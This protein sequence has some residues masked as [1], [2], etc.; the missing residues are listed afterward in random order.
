MW[1]APWNSTPRAV[2][3][4]V[5]G[6]DVCHAEIENRFV[7]RL[8]VFRAQVQPRAAAVEE[9]ELAE[10]V[11]VRQPQDAAIPRFRFRDVLHR[12]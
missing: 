2:E 11:E 5:R 6:G 3:I 7:A 4:G 9:R 8:L 12:A 10:R 1:G